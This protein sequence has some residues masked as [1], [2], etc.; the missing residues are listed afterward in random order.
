[1]EARDHEVGDP[2]EVIGALRALH[3]HP[4]EGASFV[5]RIFGTPTFFRL[6]LAQALSSLGDWLGFL[7]ILILASRLGSGAP[8][9]S[10]GL[11]MA[12]RIFSA[13][14]TLV[15]LCVLLAMAVAPL[16]ADVLDGVSDRL[17]GGQIHM[18]IEVSVPGVRP[19]LWLAGVIM[20][21]A[22][23]LSAVALG[24]LRSTPAA[25]AEHG[26]RPRERSVA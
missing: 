7:A 24:G 23:A 14:Y 10:V 6:W 12:A 5:E 8:G 11:V 3:G 15:R 26:S 4:D 16:L 2:S 9:A 1:M 18:G 21:V 13:L 22:G 20:L 17:V 19:T 25:A